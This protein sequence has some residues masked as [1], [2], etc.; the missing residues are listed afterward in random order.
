MRLAEADT[1]WFIGASG[2]MLTAIES[3]RIVESHAGQTR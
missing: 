2:G 3:S 1:R